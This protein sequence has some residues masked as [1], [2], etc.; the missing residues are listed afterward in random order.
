MLKDAKTIQ[1]AAF[2]NGAVVEKL[3]KADKKEN[4]VDGT[5]SYGNLTVSYNVFN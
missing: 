1:R 3:E 5:N 4:N 2:F